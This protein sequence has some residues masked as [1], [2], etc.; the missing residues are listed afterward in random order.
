MLKC[1]G[2]GEAGPAADESR[3]QRRGHT[4][5]GAEMHPPRL[6]AVEVYGVG[7][8]GARVD[9]ADAEGGVACGMVAAAVT[10][11]ISLEAQYG[12]GCCACRYGVDENVFD[13][14]SA[15]EV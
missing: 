1:A 12:T 13:V 9:V 11:V 8:G 14:S 4:R 3:H 7:G 2:E 15:V 5:F 10:E 6:V